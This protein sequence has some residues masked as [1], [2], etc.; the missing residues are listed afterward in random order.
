[1]SE[2]V[3]SGFFSK[4][5]LIIVR[6]FIRLMESSKKPEICALLLAAGNFK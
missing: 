1:M 5:D 2:N 6:Y 4:T 3:N